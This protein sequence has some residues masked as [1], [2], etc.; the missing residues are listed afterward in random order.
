MPSI[1]GVSHIDLTVSD[2]DSSE[3]W[4]CDLFGFRKV[5]DGGSDDHGF[6]SRYLIHPETWLIIGLVSH[7][8]HEPSE[9]FDEHRIGLDHLSFNVESH[10]ELVAWADRLDQKGIDYSPIAESV[11]WDVLVFRDPDNIQLELFYMK[12]EAGALLTA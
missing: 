9:A 12:P 7:Y 11:L 1:T 4:Y 2:L 10:D 8:D 6:S 3:H 5:V